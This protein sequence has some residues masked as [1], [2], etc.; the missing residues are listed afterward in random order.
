MLVL[1]N[2]HQ[3]GSLCDLWLLTCPHFYLWRIKLKQFRKCLLRTYTMVGVRDA[4]E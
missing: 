1:D 3:A 2:L 4:T